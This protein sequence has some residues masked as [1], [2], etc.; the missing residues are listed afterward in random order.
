MTELQLEILFAGMGFEVQ[1]V[2]IIED[3]KTGTGK[4]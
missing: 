3:I 4:G 1:N 2:R